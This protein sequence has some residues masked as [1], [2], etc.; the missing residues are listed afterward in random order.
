MGIAATRPSSTCM[1]RQ[2]GAALMV[3]LVIVVMGIAAALVGSLSA[4]ALKTA[5]QETTAAALAQ[6]KE[7][8][9]GRAASNTNIPGSLPCPDTDNDGSAEMLIG[10]ECPSYIGRLPWRTLKL[11]D[12]RDGS[13]ERL[14]Y[15]LSARFRDDN[16]ARPLNSDTQ[17]QLSV[18]GNMSIGN[19]A[20]IVF[21][22]GDPLC[23]HAQGNNNVADYLEAGDG[24]SLSYVMQSQD[25]DCSDSTYYNDE[26]QAIT[27]DQ[28]FRPVEKRVGSEI[29][30]ILNTYHAA[31]GAY[32]FAASFADPSTSS[33]T[34]VVGTDNGLLPIGNSTLPTW[35]AIPTVSISGGTI[36]GGPMDCLLSSGGATNS[37]WR[38]C[39]TGGGSSCTSNDITIPAGVTVTITGT[40]NNVGLGLWRPHHIDNVCEVRAR[41]SSG[42]TVLA[43]SILDNVAVSGN[44][45]SNG[46]ATVTFT[47]K[48]KTGGTTLRRI[49]LRDISSYNTDIRTYSNSSNC[50][51][52]SSSSPVIPKWLFSNAT[53]GNNWHQLAYYAVSPGHTQSGGTCTPLPG[54][55][56]CLTVTGSGN[57][58][59]AAVIM[60]GSNLAGHAHP[61]GNPS[62]YLEGEN[63]TPSD[64]VYENKARSGTFNDQVIV[65]AP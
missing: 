65:V 17:G 39:D 28:L 54:A 22:P 42:N 62:D 33:F 16:S 13:G 45:N 15:T 9:I 61:S 1:Y 31:W 6:A 60:T 47:T 14:W 34:G 64:F 25:N 57:N 11:S 41:D 18:T 59:R 8:L 30:Q 49:E 36:I 38:C 52:P 20:A 4:T 55:P 43:T 2:R 53:Y 46:S 24:S 21:A 40:L 3:M 19:V 58:K 5:R 35:G 29:R 37:R 26:L 50:S 23:G 12:L 56:P 48:G 63:L 7:A 27:A 44:L 10:N 32:P 51:S